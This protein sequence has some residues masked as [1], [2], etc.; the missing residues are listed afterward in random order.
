MKLVLLIVN[1]FV[2]GLCNSFSAIRSN[3]MPNDRI[4]GG[5]ETT[6][7]EHPWQVSVQYASKHR[8]GASIIGD[9]WILT[10]AH[11]TVYVNSTNVN[12]FSQ[13]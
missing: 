8:C 12:H 7:E 11:C 3:Y 4:V 13:N 5:Y 10:A 6:I 1:F 2:V 9:K